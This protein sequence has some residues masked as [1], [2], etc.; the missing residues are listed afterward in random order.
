MA[1]LQ[2]RAYAKVNIGLDVVRKLANGYHE[3]RMI[4]Q[5]IGLHDVLTIESHEEQTLMLTTDSNEMGIM[6][7]NIA[8]RAAKQLF[9][10]FSLPGGLHIHLEKR[11]PIAAGLAGGSADAA[12]VFRGINALYHLGLSQQE[13]MNRAVTIGA[14]VPYCIVGGTCLAE[15]IGE[16]LSTIDPVPECSVLVAQLPVHVS[17]KWVYEELRADEISEHPDI[18]GM[19]EAMRQG[20]L[21]LLGSRMGNV[22]QPVTVAGYPIVQRVIEQ[23]E[24]TG[25]CRVMMSG[26]GPTVFALYR[27]KEKCH[28]ACEKLKWVPDIVQLYETGCQAA[29]EEIG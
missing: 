3:V 17:T 22:L 4:M 28:E 13:L 1:K 7:E 25:A 11:I 23:I 16:K 9:E 26:S 21:E 24:Q 14:D 18:D 20:N 5:T 15:G 12:A 6:E 10:E 2:L 8:Y 27:T 19:M 29:Y